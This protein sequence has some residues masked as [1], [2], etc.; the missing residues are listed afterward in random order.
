MFQSKT[1]VSSIRGVSL[2]RN[3]AWIKPLAN[4]RATTTVL[5]QR[6]LMWSD[7]VGGQSYQIWHQNNAAMGRFSFTLHRHTC[8]GKWTP[9]IKSLQI[10]YINKTWWGTS[11]RKIHFFMV[12]QQKYLLYNTTQK[13]QATRLEMFAVRHPLDRKA[14]DDIR[15]TFAPLQLL[16]M[17]AAH[18][19]THAHKHRETEQGLAT[20]NKRFI[21]AYMN[22]TQGNR[23]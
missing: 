10:I 5:H 6:G 1:V 22:R 13:Y 18:T 20:R 15:A 23:T 9:P 11:K 8:L 3:M 14:S 4:Y 21:L 7:L 2:H 17:S 16:R 12:F 19:H